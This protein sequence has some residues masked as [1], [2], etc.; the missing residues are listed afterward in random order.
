MCDVGG[1]LV[2]GPII[3]KANILLTLYIYAY[4]CGITN[5]QCYPD[6]CQVNKNIHNGLKRLK[7][8]NPR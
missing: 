1:N 4:L 8:H 5:C 7:R 6:R 2:C 3:D